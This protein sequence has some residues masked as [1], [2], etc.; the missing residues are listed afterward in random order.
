MT[1]ITEVFF[2]L[3][4]SGL[5]ILWFRLKNKNKEFYD[6]IPG[7]PPIPFFGNILEFTS[8]TVVL[9]IMMKYMKIY[10]GVV[11]FHG[12]PIDKTLLVS[13]Y[14]FLEN[15]LSS[16]KILNKTDD[17]KFL[18]SWLG[19]GLLTSAGPKWKKHRRILTPAFH[20][21]ILEQFIDVFESAGNKLVKKLEKVVG[22]DSVDIYPFVTLC[23]LDI[24]CETAMGIKINAQDNGESEYVRS[25]KQM[26]K[27]I[28][29]RSF[30]LLQM[31]NLTYPLTKNFYIEKNALKIL[32]Q[33]TNSVINQRRQELKNQSKNIEQENDLG[34]K[35]RKA[36][37]DLILEATVD[38]RPLTDTEIREEV[39]TFMFE[40]HDTTASA[41][42]FALFC[43]AT[44][45]EVQARALEEQKALFGDTKNPTPTYTDLQN[46]KY[47]EQVIKEALR[48]YPSVPFHGRKTNEAVEFNNGTVVPKDVTI[49][50]FTYGIHR[51]PEYFK[52]PEKFD[53]SR[54]DTIDGKLPYSFIP[55][56]AGPRNCIGQK[57]AMLELKSTLSKVV[58]K[59]ELRPATPEHKLQLTAETVL[60]SVNGIKISL[61]LRQ[62]ES[63]QRILFHNHTM[64]LLT[65]VFLPLVIILLIF[66]YWYRSQKNKKYYQN[67]A[68]PPTVPIL[69]NALDFT[70]TTELLGTFMR[71][72]KD[73]GG[74]VKVHIGP[75]RHF[76]LVSDYKMLEYLLSSP[77]IVDKSEDYKF[78]SSWLGTGLLLADGG[79]KWK[80]HRKILTPAFHF[81]ILEQFVDVFD[82][83]SNV[84]IQ[85][86][87]KEVGNTSVDVYPFVTLFTLDVICESTMGTKINAQDDV[88]SDYVQSVKHM[89]RIIIERSISPVQMYD[90]LFVF[91]RNYFI[92]RRALRI[93]HDKADG[94]ISQR[95]RELQAQT[96]TDSEGD[97][98]GIKKK[99]AF[100]DL[101]LEAKVDGK[102]LSQDDI[103]QEVE[104]FMFAGHDTTA[105]AISFT[106]YCLANYPEVQKMAY[107]EQLSI[108]EDNNEPDVTYANLQ[109]M[110]YLELV[111]K[112]TLRLYPSVP[113]IGRQSGEDFQFDNSWIPKG[114]TMLLFLY[115]IH[116]DPK[117]F[118]DPE[119][120]DPNRFENPDNKMPYSYI[121]FSAGPRNC[122]GQKFA[123]LEMKCVLSKILRKF[124]LQPAVPQHNLLLTAET[125]LKSA[126]GIK[127]GIKLRK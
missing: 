110:K 107:E 33:Q 53:P 69:G 79:P 108:F 25:V 49:T 21:K 116:R 2:A 82:S 125:V 121:P 102:P 44:H 22:K 26:C 4:I 100:L 32:H 115:G 56:S 39:D 127:I 75:L 7:P 30:S 64:A 35:T 113:I 88:T 73:Y 38:G 81:Q 6:K 106:L 65:D 104:T 123:M 83:C 54:F 8:T 84:L 10:G 94:V 101:I 61:K 18:H 80:K 9:D 118:K 98:E 95:L 12:G 55:F 27:I 124:E 66:W 45:P 90:F 57:F 70:T 63:A 43:L 5:V 68:T 17:Y 67:V 31:I 47:L 105:S 126:N 77:K 1:I 52:D 89:C 40:G 46:M 51:N 74:L 93:L 91:T 122:I 96:K 41:I 14:N 42:S 15:V 58:R 19:T 78:L 76:L 114:D 20:F 99:K 13:D 72:R 23:T 109:S 97:S 29:E 50:V 92:Q 112:E 85:K 111:I 71:Y 16:T 37:L 59:F 87:D 120:F 103:R 86:L 11:K 36:F 34:T 48:L 3:L 28:I 119:V 117:Y 24:I 62:Y 60:K